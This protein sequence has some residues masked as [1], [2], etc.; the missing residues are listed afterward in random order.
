MKARDRRI[1]SKLKKN[2]SSRLEREVPV[3]YH[4]MGPVLS[5]GNVRYEM[6]DR[7]HGVSSGGISAIHELVR[8]SGLVESI[9]SNVRLLKVHRPYRESDH[10]LSLAYNVLNGG[11]CVQDL[12]LCRQDENF[13]D[14]LDAVRVPDPTTS[15]DFLRRFSHESIVQL[16]ESTNQSRRKFWRRGLSKEQRYMAYVE[17]DGTYSITDGQTKQGME[18]NH[19]G[20]WGY[21]PLVVS[22][23]NTKEPLYIVNRPANATSAQD[24]AE[25]FDRAMKHVL[26][27]FENVTFR[28]DTD[29]SQTCFL[30][31]WDET[32]RVR[33]IFGYDAYANLR[34][35]ADG[36]GK[37]AWTRL[38]RPARYEVK[39]TPR[40][41][42]TN[43]KEQIVQE[44][45]YKN[46]HLRYEDVSEFSY[47][48]TSCAKAYRM[49]VLRK[50]IKVDQGQTYLFDQVR[51]FFY[52][53]NDHDVSAS[54]IV[55][56]A[57]DR[58]DQE[59]LHSQLHSQVHA[60][61]PCSNTLESN[62]AWMVI[63][64]L[65]WTFKSWF[66][67]M[68]PDPGERNKSIRMEFKGFLNRFIRLPCQV[69][70]TS[71]RLV[72]RVLGYRPSLET[73]FATVAEIHRLF[74]LR[75]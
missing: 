3:K 15:G 66:S 10:V 11:T 46:Y 74:I 65:A 18:I 73:F 55:L 17:A 25:Y 40:E 5:G 71:R 50:T 69:V 30:D 4:W 8:A 72:L 35:I 44:R 16:M 56:E 12:E 60:L 2:L 75:V 52:I 1:V 22:L 37:S 21:H 33:F 51:Y 39:T 64:S 7:I 13:M 23:A 24:A 53:T 29:F 49:V 61:S 54:A 9:D 68:I 48:P 70:R 28:G 26:A 63:A 42:A 19:K 45:G 20:L 41:R 36:L 34:Q 27:V 67:L 38:R 43:I 58:C 14:A 31:R 47:Q 59:N 32:G 57:N 62:W 6:S